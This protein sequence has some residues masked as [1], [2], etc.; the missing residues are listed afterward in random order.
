MGAEQFSNTISVTQVLDAPTLIVIG[1]GPVGVHFINQL[2][3]SGWK[4]RIQVFGEEAVAP[5]NRVMLSSFLSGDASFS[6]IQNS[7]SPHQNLVEY[8]HCRITDINPDAQTVTDQYG[9]VHNYDKLVIATGSRPYIPNIQGVEKNGVYKFR[10]MKDTTELFARQVK[11]RHSVIIGGGLLGLETARA[12]LRHST[13]VTVVQHTANIMNRQLDEAGA[14]RLQEFAESLGIEFILNQSLKSINGNDKVTGITL[15]ELGDIECDT[16]IFATGI[17]PA[18]ELASEARLNIRK[19]IQIDEKL[20]TSH[21]NIYAIGECADFNNQVWGIVAPGL[22]QANVLAANLT[23]KD[24]VYTGAVNATELKVVGCSVLSIGTVTD[25]FSYQIGNSVIYD[26]GDVYRRIFLRGNKII[27]AVCIGDYAH[28]KQ[29]QQAVETNKYLWPW[30]KWRF[31]REG[32]LFSNDEASITDLPASTLICNCHQVDLGT[33]KQCMKACENSIESVQQETGAG[34]MCGTCKP[35]L[36]E[37]AEKPVEKVPVK[38]SL[39]AFGIIAFILSLVVLLM[40]KISPAV[41]VIEPGLTWLWTD[42]FARQTTGF[43]M[44]GLTALTVFLSLRKRWKKFTLLGFDVWRVI[45]LAV[46]SL[47]LFILFAHTGISLGDGINRWLIINFLLIALVGGISAA[48]SSVEGYYAT[49]TIK[50]F[51][52]YLVSAH[53][54]VFWPLPVLLAFHILK[55]YY[56]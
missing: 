33:I 34:T 52:R 12:M 45:H 14:K 28:T 15:S 31:A 35:L 24:K 55:V 10:D 21:R 25:E 41:S 51:K 26:K 53:I 18:T 37:L 5:Y 43:T 19:G 23:G 8:L 7:I 29:L 16:V 40:P 42:S 56:F 27:G 39:L 11:S 48:M 36:Q 2:I 1:N 50:R 22:A 20:Q 30:D 38:K 3:K 13:N 47:A 32:S 46:T 4:G 44:L 17:S 49:T 54:I 6:D 9:Q